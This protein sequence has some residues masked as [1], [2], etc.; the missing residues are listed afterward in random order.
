MA[1]CE[2]MKGERGGP[3][4]RSTYYRPTTGGEEVRFRFDCRTA[5]LPAGCKLAGREKNRLCDAKMQK[6]CVA[7]VHDA[8][9]T[10]K[11]LKARATAALSKEEKVEKGW[12]DTGTGK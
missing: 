5:G 8:M 12:V 4:V 9:M 1:S 7:W 3:A 6:R 11:K 2:G 10:V